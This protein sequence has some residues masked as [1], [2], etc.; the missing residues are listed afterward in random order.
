MANG[1][2]AMAEGSAGLTAGTLAKSQGTRYPRVDFGQEMSRWLSLA[3]V[4]QQSR[5]VIG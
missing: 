3:Y 5:I 1:L 4:D 2:W